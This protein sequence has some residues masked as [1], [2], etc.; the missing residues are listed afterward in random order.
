MKRTAR[1][2]FI[3]A[4]L[5]FQGVFGFL[6]VPSFA[7][8][9]AYQALLYGLYDQHFPVVKPSQ[10]TD[11]TN[12]QI[13][14]TRE[15]AEFDISH[16]EGAHWVGYDT[17]SLEAVK[18]LD[19]NQLVL[20]YCTVGARSQE[21]GKRLQQAGFTRVFNLYGG[22]IEWVNEDHGVVANGKPTQK[23]HTY[24]QAWGIWLSK[25][26]KVY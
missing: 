15:K 7:Q 13:L 22:I 24:S 12:Y 18:D 21:I 3:F 9:P 19:K 23:I 1:Y 2:H 17:F 10:I 4:F 11:L 26:E 20:V 14:D 5:L 25:G 8:T 6:S 16:L